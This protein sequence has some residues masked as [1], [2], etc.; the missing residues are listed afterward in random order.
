MD[1]WE[2]MYLDLVKKMGEEPDFTR[3]V[4]YLKY[5]VDLLYNQWFYYNNRNAYIVS[6]FLIPIYRL[7]DSIAGY[8]VAYPL[9][10]KSIPLEE[11]EETLKKIGD[12]LNKRTA[13]SLC[14]SLEQLIKKLMEIEQKLTLT[15]DAVEYNY[16]Y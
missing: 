16:E 7:L 9:Q 1:D 8:T 2:N 3:K 14:N 11:I 4:V 15:R 12:L 13:S 5:I 6:H 10:E